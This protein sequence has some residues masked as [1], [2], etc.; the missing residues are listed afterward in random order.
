MKPGVKEDCLGDDV[1]ANAQEEVVLLSDEANG[2]PSLSTLSLPAA[3]ADRSFR[4]D[5]DRLA[6]LTL[7]HTQPGVHLNDYLTR[8]LRNEWVIRLA[9]G[10]QADSQRNQD[11]RDLVRRRRFD[12]PRWTS[13]PDISMPYMKPEFAYLPERR[14]IRHR[15]LGLRDEAEWVVVPTIA[16]TD[17]RMPWRPV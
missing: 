15:V 11:R 17:P 8:P 14:S 3:L 5:F 12:L 7:T 10:K 16:T 2:S 6:E 4:E 9:D 13:G 1:D